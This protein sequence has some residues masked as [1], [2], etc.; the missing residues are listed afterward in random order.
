MRGNVQEPSMTDQRQ[1][2][3]FEGIS[4][5]STPN[6]R[7]KVTVSL[8][9]CDRVIEGFAEGLETHQG[10]IQ[11]AANA[12]LRAAMSAAG[13]RLHF[14]IAGVKSVRAFDGWVV[15]MR[16]NGEAESRTHRLLGSAS[17]E[18][19]AELPRTAAFALLDATNRLLEK[20]VGS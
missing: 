4:L 13:K 8:E 18:G 5:E 12:T 20:H 9:W 11:A 17:C 2:L 16:V 7:C 15:I 14:E 1:R 3:R 6:G 10:R 19:E